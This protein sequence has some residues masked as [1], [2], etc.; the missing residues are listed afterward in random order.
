MI[1]EKE[2]IIISAYDVTKKK[3]I[4][5][6]GSVSLCSRYLYS[7]NVKRE[8]KYNYIRNALATKYRLRETILEV[9]VVLRHANRD[10]I[11]LLK[12]KDF[13]IVQG[14]PQPYENKIYGFNSPR[15]SLYEQL[16]RDSVRRVAIYSQ[17]NK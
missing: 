16:K 11:S 8:N 5:V 3:L 15:T 6:F 1:N 13:Y 14:Y 10:Q 4:G 7:S 9:P 17:Q 2:K 12:D